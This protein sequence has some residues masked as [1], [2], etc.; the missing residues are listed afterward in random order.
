MKTPSNA[1]VLV[2]AYGDNET[3]A[4]LKVLIPLS[5][6]YLFSP[7]DFIPD[8]IPLAGWIDDLIVVPALIL[9]VINHLPA[10]VYRRASKK[11]KNFKLLFASITILILLIFTF[12][13][14]F[15]TRLIFF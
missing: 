7:I 1:Q 8:F 15:L 6:L 11:A 5:F 4:F 10:P 3:P 14:V 2:W 12:F 13:L 9:F